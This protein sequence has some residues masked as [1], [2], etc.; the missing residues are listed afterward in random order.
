MT[1]RCVQLYLTREQYNELH[2]IINNVNANGNNND[3]N[4]MPLCT[5]RCSLLKTKKKKIELQRRPGRQ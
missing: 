2:C 5:Q 1:L 4:V 3:N